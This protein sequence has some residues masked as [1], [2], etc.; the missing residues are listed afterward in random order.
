MIDAYGT[1]DFYYTR[2]YNGMNSRQKL[3]IL[4]APK[5]D[6]FPASWQGFGTSLHKL[7]LVADREPGAWKLTAAG[8]DFQTRILEI[9][10]RNK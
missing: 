1:A 3:I 5:H 9:I 10:M 2:L 6:W 4:E 7:G 8:R